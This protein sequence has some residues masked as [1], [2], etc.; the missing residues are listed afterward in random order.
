MPA[1]KEIKETNV[2]G[3]WLRA[4]R[5]LRISMYGT[6]IT[7]KRKN[8][9]TNKANNVLSNYI[10]IQYIYVILYTHIYIYIYA[11]T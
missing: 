11:Y 10:K 5:R 4:A 7:T 3:G 2:S 8:K 1:E 9:K 6:C